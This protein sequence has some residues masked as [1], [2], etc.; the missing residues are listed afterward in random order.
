MIFSTWTLLAGLA[1]ITG[2]QG[3]FVNQTTCNGK[4]YTYQELAGYGLIPGNSTDQF[5]DTIGG[6][7]SAIALDRFQWR[8]LLNGSYTGVLW[9]LPDRGWNTEGT[10]NFQP[11]VHKFDILFTPQPDATVQKP[12]GNNL[13][14]KYKETIL[15]YGPDGTPCTGLDADGTGHLS[16]PG[17]P[18]LPV[19]TYTGDGFGGAGPGGQRIPID[20]EGIILN[21]D[22]SF[23]ISDEYGPY[24]YRFSPLGVM[25]T[26][27]RPPNAIIPMRNGTESFSADSPTFY[28]GETDDVNPADNPTGRDNNHGFEGLTI[29]GDGRTLYVLL[30][31]AAN[32]EGGLNKQTERYARL[33]Q[34]DITIPFAPLYTGEYV[35][36]LP[37]YND[38]T[39]KASKNPQVAAQSEIFHIQDGQFFV[40]SRDS[41]AGHGQAVSTSVYRHIDVLDIGSAT[42]IK[43]SAY[44]CTNCS[45]ATSSG[46]LNSDITPATYCSFIDYNVNSQLNRFGVHNGGAQDSSLLNEKWE[47]IGLVP[48]DGLFGADN[49]WYVFSLSDDDFITQD[50]HLNFGLF[51]YT[52]STGYNLDNQALVFKV[53]LPP[54]SFIPF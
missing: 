40:L 53:G 2:V 10:L 25:I 26:A 11:R 17:F 15:F 41:N 12:S 9:A 49:E 52:D 21:T 19:A 23:W 24:V 3:T 45:I 37:L 27:I 28:G 50:G 30:Q 29:S 46:N 18:D 51:A 35:V 22:G 13:L 7:G 44:D 38:P 47:S 43:G 8:R 31:A 36:P 6:I 54:G 1:A 20:S 33:V 5:G 39:A 34:Y 14:F 48:V 4:T 42:D 16:Y 32:Q